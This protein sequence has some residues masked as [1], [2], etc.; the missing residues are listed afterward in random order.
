MFD[1]AVSLLTAAV[2]GIAPALEAARVDL[3]E[4]LKE[5]SKGAG[6]Q[7]ARSGRLRGLLVVAEVALALVLLISAGLL[8]KS[9]DRLRNVDAGFDTENVLTMTLRLPGG[10]YRENR[11]LVSFF[12]PAT[13]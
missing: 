3:N 2:F 10:K 1:R 12:R 13:S 5:G 4:A 8:L 7:G 9:F 6:G 11:Q